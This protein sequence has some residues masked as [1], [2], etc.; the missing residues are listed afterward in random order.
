MLNADRAEVEAIARRIAREEIALAL[1][2][3]TEL[4]VVEE[5]A[6][7]VVVEPPAPDPVVVDE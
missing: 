3:P 7:E 5:A 4:T 1:A 6:P 2:P